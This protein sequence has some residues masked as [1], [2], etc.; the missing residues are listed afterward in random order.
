M[1]DKKGGY[2]RYDGV[3]F[4]PDTFRAGKVEGFAPQGGLL[5]YY[6]GKGGGDLVRFQF[7]GGKSEFEN[8]RSLDTAVA[9]DGRLFETIFG[10]NWSEPLPAEYFEH[11]PYQVVAVR[12]IR[13]R[14]PQ[15]AEVINTDP[16][17]QKPFPAPAAAEQKT[18]SAN[19]LPRTVP[20]DEH[21]SR[22]STF[23]IICL[24]AIAVALGS[25]W[26]IV[27]RRS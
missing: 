17:V 4:R 7:S 13:A 1:P 26:Y 9:E 23:W 12:D 14:M 11:P 3:E 5:A 27:A 19:V 22:S 24:I 16:K 8:L 20:S 6:P 15:S 18:T 25:L 10:R 21:G 2:I